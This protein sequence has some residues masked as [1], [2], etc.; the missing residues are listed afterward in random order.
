MTRS[1]LGVSVFTATVSADGYSLTSRVLT[2]GQPCPGTGVL[3]TCVGTNLATGTIRWFI[4]AD[5][6]STFTSTSNST[7]YPST[8]QSKLPGVNVTI[9]T[10]QDRDGAFTFVNTT[11]R[12]VVT[13]HTRSVGCGSLNTVN[14]TRL[15]CSTAGPGE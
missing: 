5:Q 1:P 7:T 8:V 12:T 4:N 2:D 6:I 11:L 3:F 9:V 13:S 14:T 15:D 10:A